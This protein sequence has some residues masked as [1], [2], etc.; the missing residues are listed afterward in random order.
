MDMLSAVQFN[1]PKKLLDSAIV[2]LSEIQHQVAEEEEE[3]PE[4]IGESDKEEDDEDDSAEII[5]AKNISL[6]KYT[7]YRDRHPRLPVKL[8][9]DENRIIAYEL[10]Y[11][12]HTRPCG[13]ITMAMGNWSNDFDAM[14]ECDII[15]NPNTRRVGD[16]AFRPCRHLCPELGQENTEGEAYPTMVV[17]VGI[18]Q[19]FRSLYRAAEQYFSPRTT[20]QIYLAIKVFPRQTDG[21]QPM[22]AMRFLRTNPVSM[23]P[24][25]VKSF[26][27]GPITRRMKDYFRDRGIPDANITGVGIPGAPACNAAGIGF[28]QMNFPAALLYSGNP[29]GAPGELAA[30]FNL[31]LW[32][33]QD[34]VLRR[35]YVHF[36]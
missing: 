16:V 6:K 32:T 4:P 35:M 30:G 1:L 17:E 19:P 8:R 2:R 36:S 11:G 20:I 5:L 21:R 18:S 14:P 34:A 23:R 3:G 15:T 33:V 7:A 26:G 25:I 29:D 13:K 24:D 22:V 9:L 27:T 28:Y 31:D 12:P 10:P